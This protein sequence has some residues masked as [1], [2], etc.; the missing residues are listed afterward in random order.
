MHSKTKYT[1]PPDIAALAKSYNVLELASSLRHLVSASYLGKNLEAFSKADLHWLVNEMLL[2]QFKG[3]VT[4]KA[5]LVNLFLRQNVTAAFEIKVHRSRADFLTLNGV[6]KSFEIKSAL[7]N[8]Q[9]LPKQINDYLRVFDYNYLVIDECHYKKVLTIIPDHYGI[10]VLHGH[11]LTEDRPAALNTCLDSETQL[12]LFTKKEFAQTF[13]IPGISM[14]E[15]LI[16][17]EPEEINDCFKGM[18][19]KKYARKWEFI[20]KNAAVIHEIDYQF[21]F[22]HNIAPHIIYG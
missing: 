11:Q 6:S 13:R 3:E 12:K 16:N 14:H 1:T 9:K 20:C 21:F 4:L 7:D 8:L 5:R 2:E 10:M 19:Q 22:Q 17:F 15:V 18:L